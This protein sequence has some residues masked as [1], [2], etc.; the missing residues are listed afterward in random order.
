MKR[1]TFKLKLLSLL[2]AF[3]MI[4]PMLS[5]SLAFAV[6]SEGWF[7]SHYVEVNK[8]GSFNKDQVT[9][10][11]DP[12]NTPDDTM[13]VAKTALPETFTVMYIY[14]DDNGDQWYWLDTENW[15]DAYAEYVAYYFVSVDDVTL[16]GESSGTAVVGYRAKFAE[17]YQT[18][19][20][21]V[22]VYSDPENSADMQRILVSDLPSIFKITDVYTDESEGG[23]TW[24]RIDSLYDG[25]WPEEYADYH[26]V[27][28]Y[29][30]D[31][32][33]V[34]FTNAA[35][36]IESSAIVTPFSAR[37]LSA[38]AVA[39][40]GSTPDGL[41]LSK[42]VEVV[43]GGYRIT[44][45]AYTTGTVMV[46]QTTK[47][48][49]VVVV[50]DQS[51]S[52]KY[53]VGCD[54]KDITTN[55]NHTE[56][57]YSEEY[58]LNTNSTYYI[59]INNSHEE[60]EYCDDCEAWTN[61]CTTGRWGRH[62]Q[63]TIYTPKTSASD[64]SNAN[65][66]FYNRTGETVSCCTR[67]DA[68]NTAL[69]SFVENV[70]EKS[71]D[72][73]DHRIAIV[74]FASGSHD[75]NNTELLTGVDIETVDPTDLIDNNDTCYY[76]YDVA[77][78]GVQYEDKINGNSLVDLITDVQYAAALQ[79]MSTEAGRTS[80][81]EAIKALTA[82]GGTHT[83]Y[84]LDMAYQ[85]LE[86]DTKKDEDR[87][88]V[89]ILFTDGAT[90]SDR[91]DLI[92]RAHD[93][94]DEYNATVY[95]VGIF[96]GANGSLDSYT[97][98]IN[99][100]NT[101][102]HLISSNYPDAQ[103]NNNNI[104]EGDVNPNLKDGESYYLSAD[105]AN[106][107]N[108]IF[109]SISQQIGAT[110]MD[111]GT[112][113]VVKD[114]VSP[115]FTMPSGTSDIS[116][117]AV[118]CLGY[119]DGVPTWAT[120]GTTL[121]NAVTI[122]DDNNTVDVTGFD[123]KANYVAANGRDEADE[124]QSG[125]FHGRKL[126]IQFT[127]ELKSDFLGGSHIPTNGEQSGIYDNEGNPVGTFDV[128][129]IDVPLK[130][131][132]P[133]SQDQHIYL[134]NPGSLPVVSNIGKFVVNGT[135]YEVDGVNNAYVDIVYKISDA[136]GNVLGTYTVSAGTPYVSL[137]NQ[138]WSDE[139]IIAPLLTD[140]TTYTITCSVTSVSD[141]TETKTGDS[142][143]ATV[144]VYKPVI[145]FQD[146]VVDGGATANY[147]DNFVSVVW[148]NSNIGEADTS[149]MGAAPALIYS[150][151]PEAGVVDTD[152]NVKVSVSIN[153]EDFTEY[154]TFNRVACNFAGC[155]HPTASVVDA[156]D[157]DRVNFVVHVRYTT[158]TITK[159]GANEKL[160]PNQTFIFNVNGDG[161]D[162]DV[163]I[164]G[165]DSVTIAGLKVG[166]TYTV[167]E[168]TWSWR[169][170][171]SSAS[172]VKTLTANETENVLTFTNTRDQSKWLD[173]NAWADNLFNQTTV[174]GN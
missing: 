73:V 158:L 45:E 79:D 3:A 91:E 163:T 152:L 87:N 47:P 173:G 122:N 72:G 20:A 132:D 33:T 164:H 120:E 94:K 60:V 7:D 153:D 113:T 18:D 81:D 53:C 39:R 121:N 83:L 125:D 16:A 170:E 112:E 28:D 128:P 65:T 143:N 100:N 43:D 32:V 63:G 131:I 96:E 80:V 95:S 109:V 146:T 42:N 15:G 93:I 84:G 31:F 157:A 78:N 34:N 4:V 11:A 159:S 161:V 44:L 130:S 107:L 135:T 103:V 160:D 89:V 6:P 12:Y 134:G 66:Q 46:Q 1:T 149:I 88:K 142:A 111:L 168:K 8:E 56:Y 117:K 69:K 61:G 71:V 165:N 138:G 68:L 110:S 35:P 40:A 90:N 59:Y 123:F 70:T 116:V 10:Y 102:M 98:N 171:P 108:S 50:V 140:D 124:T 54:D 58:I 23:Y 129:E 151:D 115:Y 99:N 162:L 9:L 119:V 19:T 150:Y 13:V 48:M 126:V 114:I 25:G 86:N 51:G 67:L 169:Y 127:V 14:S 145:T 27:Y 137:S 21:E 136:A 172:Q 104:N 118:D 17:V 36:I 30:V 26:Y 174:N 105:N 148:K 92:N 64:T 75:Y 141:E 144:Y 76:P 37:M 55:D 167:T 139:G 106:A 166:E 77:Y 29:T 52:M 133:V 2:L 97:D 101:V 49:D 85:I 5:Q 22:I 38:R 74:G 62:I 41:E 154:V 24:Y 147:E 57:K 82:H 155:D 156:T